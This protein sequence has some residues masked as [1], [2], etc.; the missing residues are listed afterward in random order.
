[1]INK[2][3]LTILVCLA[4]NVPAILFN[5]KAN[6]DYES[7]DRV[8]AIVEKSVVTK[9]ELEGAITVIL[10]KL[11]K[12]KRKAPSRNILEK[13]VLN[14]LIEKKLI[15]QYAEL[16]GIKVESQYLESVIV[17]IAETNNLTIDELRKNIKEEGIDFNKFK[18]GISYE[19]LLNQVKEREITSKINVSDFEIENI[20]KNRI[21]KAPPEFRISH[22]LLKKEQG[23]KMG[24]EK[25]NKILN[26]LKTDKFSNVAIN[27][28]Y[29][30]MASRGGVLGWK[31]IEELP[32]IFF[33]AINKM[34][35][36]DISEPL[37]SG[38]GI[39]ILKLDDAKN[40]N[41]KNK[42][43]MSE[44]YSISQILIKKNE[45]NNEEDI[46]K[47]LKNI[48][49]QILEGLTFSLAASK[50]SEDPSSLNDGDLGWVD[51]SVML[52]KYKTAVE[53]SELGKVSGPFATEVGWV[54]LL[55]AEKRNKDITDEKN[56]ISAR[57]ELLQRKTQIKYKDWFESLKAQVHIEILLNE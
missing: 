56:K 46:K 20:L 9:K 2:R 53:T 11:K 43:I 16:I 8:I 30:P 34:N 36:G 54:L 5:L 33:E 39:H 48:K 28:S 21:S 51:K 7:I 15:T 4:L 42:K 50:Y 27:K 57:V 47:K 13:E 32:E 22:I 31:K 44:Q 24:G 45:I 6:D 23:Y 19:L 1:M 10:L 29:G 49:N 17:N 14:K 52:P 25:L 38:N 37:I 40:S 26:Q 35:V 55:V 12:E 18:E 41:K 3:I